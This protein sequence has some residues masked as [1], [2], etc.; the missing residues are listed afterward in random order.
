MA[1]NT[2]CYAFMIKKR[3]GQIKSHDEWL[4]PY[5]VS[6]TLALLDKEIPRLKNKVK[7]DL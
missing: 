6:N 1:A 3:F 2:P 4:E 5:L 7:S